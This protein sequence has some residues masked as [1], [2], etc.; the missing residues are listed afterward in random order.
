MKQNSKIRKVIKKIIKE[1]TI[2]AISSVTSNDVLNAMQKASNKFTTAKLLISVIPEITSSMVYAFLM[3]ITDSKTK[4]NVINII[5]QRFKPK[6]EY[7]IYELI[8]QSPDIQKTINNIGRDTIA[9]S[10]ESSFIKDLLL[11]ADDV[12]EMANALGNNIINKLSN[13]Q[14]TS[15]INMLIN[16]DAIVSALG[17]KN[18][19][20]LNHDNIKHLIDSCLFDSEKEQTIK[21]LTMYI[22]EK[23]L[24]KILGK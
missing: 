9:K 1:D 10:L 24:Y 19:K 6:N 7:V 23:K 21:A 20:K 17:E 22:P 13:K 2:G 8:K 18:I 4:Q 16:K 12:E 5:V 11:T 14:I 15:L 3:Y